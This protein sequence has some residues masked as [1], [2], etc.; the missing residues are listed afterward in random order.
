MSD[1]GAATS[2]GCDAFRRNLDCS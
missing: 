1:V 2:Q